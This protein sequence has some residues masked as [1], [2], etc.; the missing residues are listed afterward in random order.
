MTTGRLAFR[1]KD[2]KTEMPLPYSP[3]VTPDTAS[4]APSLALQ[5]PSPATPT[6]GEVLSTLR[7]LAGLSQADLAS[8]VGVSQVTISSYEQDKQYFS[9]ERAAEFFRVLSPLIKER[10]QIYF[11]IEQAQAPDAQ[12]PDP[13]P[14]GMI[15]SIA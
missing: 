14:A 7:T 6:P 8:L 4:G 2:M 11:Q 5:V 15:S 9:P 1:L 10:I 12:S 3:P 13:Y